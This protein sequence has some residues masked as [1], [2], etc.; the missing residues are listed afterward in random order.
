M[1]LRPNFHLAEMYVDNCY[2]TRHFIHE[3]WGAN[4]SGEAT[5]F[6]RE[7]ELNPGISEGSTSDL[8]FSAKLSIDLHIYTHVHAFSES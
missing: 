5:G 7:E 1:A 2:V 3:L 8:Q 6:G 4:Y